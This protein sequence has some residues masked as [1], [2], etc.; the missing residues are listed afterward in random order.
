MTKSSNDK[1]SI[2]NLN[3]PSFS[4]YINFIRF[5]RSVSILN[6]VDYNKKTAMD[7]LINELDW[8]KYEGKHYESFYTKFYQGYILPNQF[9]IDKRYGHLSDLINSKQLSRDQAKDEIGKSPYNFDSTT[10]QS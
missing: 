7:L 4:L 5:V 1:F 8:S 2:L 6:Y 3:W 9:S 10:N